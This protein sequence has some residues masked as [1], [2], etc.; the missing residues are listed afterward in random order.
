MS[1]SPNLSDLI[2]DH[3]PRSMDTK[4]DHQFLTGCADTRYLRAHLPE[5]EL[6]AFHRWQQSGRRALD[7]PWS[8]EVLALIDFELGVLVRLRDLMVDARANITNP[9]LLAEAD[10]MRQGREGTVCIQQLR[11][12]HNVRGKSFTLLPPSNR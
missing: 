4:S 10:K 8:D 11:E 12:I 7:F 9:D 6:L 2:G 5:S 3:I 1:Q